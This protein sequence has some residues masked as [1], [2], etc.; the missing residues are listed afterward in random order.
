MKIAHD[1]YRIPGI[2]ETNNFMPV[3]AVSVCSTLGTNCEIVRI[4]PA[5]AAPIP[6]PAFC[7]KTAAEKYKPVERRPLFHSP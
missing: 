5:M 1:M 7:A 4:Q 2:T 3:I 6:Q